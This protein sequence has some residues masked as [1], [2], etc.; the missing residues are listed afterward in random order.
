MGKEKIFWALKIF[1]GIQNWEFCPTFVACP[2]NCCG[3]VCWNLLGML[4]IL[5]RYAYSILIQMKFY[6]R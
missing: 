1:Y 4:I 6:F 2:E 5:S 3:P